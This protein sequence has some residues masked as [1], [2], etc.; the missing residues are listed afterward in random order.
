MNPDKNEFEKLQNEEA[1]KAVGKTKRVV[2]YQFLLL[3]KKKTIKGY[4]FRVQQIRLNDD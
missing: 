3:V 2:I 1:M 4:I